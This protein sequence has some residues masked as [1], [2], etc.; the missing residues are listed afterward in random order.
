MD[1]IRSGDL[2]FRDGIFGIRSKAGSELVSDFAVGDVEISCDTSRMLPAGYAQIGGETFHYSS[3]SATKLLGVTGGTVPHLAGE[4]V[5][6]LYSVPANFDRANSVWITAP[7]QYGRK[8]PVPLDQSETY[9]TYYSVIRYGTLQLLKISGVPTDSVLNC[10]YSVK[11][12]PMSEDSD[13]CPIPDGYGI[14]VI[15]PLVAGE[16]AFVRGM[17]NGAQILTSAYSSLRN[18]YQFFTNATNVVKQSIKPQSY[19]FASV[20]RPAPANR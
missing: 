15:S 19:K 4:K 16:M 13:V 10:S 11:I 5:V 7:G 18:M 14:S 8:V 9:A 2:W 20:N 1:V 3:V 17:P 12:N 6:Q